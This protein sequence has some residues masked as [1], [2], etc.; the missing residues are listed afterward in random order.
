MNG[1]SIEQLGFL[2][3]QKVPLDK[4]FDA[5]GLSKS[6]YR[7]LMKEQGKIVAFNVS[8]CTSSGHTLR[9]RSGHCVQ[10]NTA[11]L[12]FQKR[13]D[14]SGYI[15]IAGTKRGEIIKVG[16]AETIE[17]RQKSLVESKYAGFDDWKIL[18]T[19]FFP[20]SGIIERSMQDKLNKYSRKLFYKHDGKM[21][22]ASE[23]YSCSLSK[24]KN[25]LFEICNDLNIDY[26]LSKNY[27]LDDYEFRN[28]AK[29]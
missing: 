21:Q 11:Y 18:I 23:I 22:E 27:T 29:K 16:F 2:K 1:L 12:G 6:E 8:P 5:L 26:N 20:N 19:I 15:Y 9:T 7:V 14:T 4:V 28:L 3:E 10:C 13:H 25:I 24:A 17:Y